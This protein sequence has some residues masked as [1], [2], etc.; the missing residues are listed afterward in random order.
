VAPGHAHPRTGGMNRRSQQDL[1]AEKGD[2]EQ[3]EVSIEEIFSLLW[4]IPKADKS[5][6][7]N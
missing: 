5:R 1:V 7:P 6:V 4:V 3:E 2:T